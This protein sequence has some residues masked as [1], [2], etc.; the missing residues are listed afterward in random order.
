MAIVRI[1]AHNIPYKIREKYREGKL[2]IKNSRRPNC[3]ITIN[4]IILVI[5]LADVLR[6]STEEFNFRYK[7]T[8]R[9]YR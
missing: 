4:P 9:H 5:K 2:I 3:K 8:R 6:Y 1:K 7:R